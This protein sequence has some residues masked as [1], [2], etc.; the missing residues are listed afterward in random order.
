MA[1]AVGTG[2]GDGGSTARVAVTGVTGRVGGGVARALAAAGIGQRMLA[3]APERAPSLP[4]ASVHRAS[5]DD[6]AAVRRALAGVETVLFVS[7]AESADRLAQHATFV[8]AAA[9]AGVR[10]VVYTSFVGASPDSVFT[11]GRD[12]GATEALIEDSGMAHTFLRDN[13][14]ADFF[15]GLAGEDGVI[16]GPAGDGAVSAVAISDVVDAAAAVLR[17]PVE[18]RG[19][20]HDLTGPAALTLAEVAATVSSVT[21]RRVTYLDETLA[22]AHASRASYG[23]PDWQVEAWVSTYTAVASGALAAVSDD[24][25]RLTGHPATPFADVVRR[26]TA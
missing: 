9:D 2:A 26:A 20:V 17:T 25:Q 14:Y 5:Y 10:S 23:V 15:A 7:G 6:G 18:A 4:G 16:R 21:G 13:F 8:D 12:H 11:L 3:R 22:Q 24:V 19:V 1:D